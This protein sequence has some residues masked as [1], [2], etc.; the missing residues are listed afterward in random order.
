MGFDDSWLDLMFT[1][2]N[3]LLGVACLHVALFSKPA[4]AAAR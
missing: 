1:A 2:F 4:A 3:G